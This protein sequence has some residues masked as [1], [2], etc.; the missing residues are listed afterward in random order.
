[1]CKNVQKKGPKS[2]ILWGKKLC[3]RNQSVHEELLRIARGAS[4]SERSVWH[5]GANGVHCGR[6]VKLSITGIPASPV[7]VRQAAE[8]RRKRWR[9]SSLT[10]PESTPASK[11]TTGTLCYC[12]GRT[13]CDVNSVM[14]GRRPSDQFAIRANTHTNPLREDF[15][16]CPPSILSIVLCIFI[17]TSMSPPSVSEIGSPI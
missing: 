9:A 7:I 6:L 16:C 5:R 1:M 4:V 8:C 2:P 12:Y 13:F 3:M 10:C 14:R 17:G 11:R 15:S